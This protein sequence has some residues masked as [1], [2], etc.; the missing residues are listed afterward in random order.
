MVPKDLLFLHYG[1]GFA[2][3]PVCALSGHNFLP[4]FGS[5]LSGQGGI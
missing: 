3:W 4:F 1:S 5:A 2:K